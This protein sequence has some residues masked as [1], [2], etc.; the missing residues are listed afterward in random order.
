MEVEKW[1]VNDKQLENS[2]HASRKGRSRAIPKA[3]SAQLAFAGTLFRVSSPG[4]V[5]S[6]APGGCRIT[7]PL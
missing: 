2:R 4:Q 5:S 7:A 1:A 6:Q 3:S